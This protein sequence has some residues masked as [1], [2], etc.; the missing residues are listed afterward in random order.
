MFS[1]SSAAWFALAGR[2]GKPGRGTVVALQSV[3]WFALLAREFPKTLSAADRAHTILPENI[4]I[5]SN[6]A[7]ALMFM[8][9]ADEAKALYLAYKAACNLAGYATE[10]PMDRFVHEQNLRYLREVLARTIDQ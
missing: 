3:A 5:E 8:E 10:A 2:D 1:L 4:S 9:H 7:H 6:R